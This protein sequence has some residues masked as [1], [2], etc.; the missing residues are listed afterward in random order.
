M[1][2]HSTLDWNKYFPRSIIDCLCVPLTVN[3]NVPKNVKYG[4]EAEVFGWMKEDKMSTF[5]LRCRCK[6]YRPCHKYSVSKACLM[7]TVDAWETIRL[8]YFFLAIY[9]KNHITEEWSWWTM[10]AL[11]WK[12]FACSRNR[13]IFWCPIFNSPTIGTVSYGASDKMILK[14]SQI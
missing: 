1:H 13:C 7:Q 8:M 3:V 9:R 6:Q 10:N 2:S 4:P 12:Y 11:A 5:L 14:S